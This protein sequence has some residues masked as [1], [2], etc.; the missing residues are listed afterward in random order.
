[1]HRVSFLKKFNIFLFLLAV[2]VSLCAEKY[3]SVFFDYSTKMGQLTAVAIIAYNRPKYFKQ[4]LDSLVKNPESQNLPFFFFLDGGDQKAQDEN[5]RLIESAPFP[6]KF[7]IA[8]D[9]N[10][11][12]PKNYVDSHRFLFDWC[13]FERIVVLEEDLIV[14]KKYFEVLFHLYDLAHTNYSNIGMVQ[15][16][17]ECRLNKIHKQ[18]HLGSVQEVIPRWSQMTYCIGKKSW[19]AISSKLYYYEENFIN[20]LLGKRKYNKARSKPEFART[21]KNFQKW[22]RKILRS[23]DRA[24]ALSA[25]KP[26]TWISEYN[27][28]DWYCDGIRG[29]SS[30]QDELIGLL[31]WLAGYTRLQTV[32]NRVQHIGSFGISGENKKADIQLDAFEEDGIHVAFC[33]AAL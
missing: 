18:I 33:P 11:G 27:M 3:D 14:S 30:N 13:N 26:N 24:H 22:I 7:V 4:L 19:D 6:Q 25:F 17:S 16:W 5:K 15:L 12:C 20:P 31:L 1:M 28:K 2:C 23:T 32:V 8:R 10:Y 21:H 29:Y 9:I